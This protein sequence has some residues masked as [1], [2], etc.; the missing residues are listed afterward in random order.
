MAEY[1]KIKTKL[2]TSDVVQNACEILEFQS[3]KVEQIQGFLMLISDSNKKLLDIFSNL[4]QIPSPSKAEDDVILWL[5]DYCKAN[6]LNCELDKYGNVYIR[7]ARTCKS[8]KSILLSAHMDV[9]GDFSPIN[10]K[11]EGDFIKT[12]G[13]RTLGADDKA[14]IA[15]ALLLALEIS[16]DEELEHGGLELVF[17]R[18]EEHGMSGIK[19]VEFEKLNSTYALVL[20][21]N[22]LGRLEVSGAGYTNGILKVHAKLG[23]HSGL[24]IQDKNR[25]N[26]AKL[27]AELTEMIP[28]GMFF[29]NEKGTITSINLGTVIAGD[30][31]NLVSKAIDEK[32]KS[33]NY[34]DYLIE[35]SV[36]NVINTE[37]RASYSIR[38]ASLDK[39]KELKTLI[40][41]KIEEF[42]KKYSNLAK[43]EMT[44]SEHLPLFEKSEDDTIEK[45]H[46]I[47]CDKNQIK[48][49]IGSCHCGAETHIYAKNKNAKGERFIPFL[50][51]I[52][53]LYNT[54]SSAEKIDFKSFIK[55][56]EM[57][58]ELFLEF[59]T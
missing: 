8:K 20:D 36:T 21:S 19:H 23:G 48:Q 12:D 32:I 46:A 11:T 44:Y 49:I 37:A 38:S 15:C 51:G 35:N 16:Q 56:Y 43:A 27:I 14:G 1:T 25:L 24:D 3:V 30:I 34:M 53:D 41:S 33:D 42:N 2:P 9:I 7:V 26:A 6:R 13:T 50:T 45:L 58:K 22:K 28:Q 54:H 47:A 17:T 5:E 57:L 10:L 59:N 52:A 18:D 39:E 4:A 55:G 29:G 40:N 31:Q